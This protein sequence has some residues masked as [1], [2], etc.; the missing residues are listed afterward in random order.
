M[1]CQKE[2]GWQV[3]PQTVPRYQCLCHWNTAQLLLICRCLISPDLSVICT[4]M[5]EHSQVAQEI[6]PEKVAVPA[7]INVSAWFAN[8][9]K[10]NDGTAVAWEPRLLALFPVCPCSCLPASVMISLTL[11]FPSK[12]RHSH[13]QCKISRTATHYVPNPRDF[14]Q[15]GA[16]LGVEMP[17]KDSIFPE[18]LQTGI[19]WGKHMGAVKET[20]IK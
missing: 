9:W 19:N 4:T 10:T 14:Y 6:L 15:Q 8:L 7:V 1:P 12:M 3:P 5:Q 18:S 16:P 13:F 11:D 2:R 17:E 20:Q